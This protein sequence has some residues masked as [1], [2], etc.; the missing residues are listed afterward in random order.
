MKYLK[1]CAKITL[2]GNKLVCE[3]TS[4]KRVDY[5]YDGNGILYGLIY[6]GNK[7]FYLRDHLANILGIIDSSGNLV[8]SYDYSAYGNLKSITGSLAT[9]LGVDN[10]MRYKGYYFDEETGFYYCKSRY[11]VPEWCRWL[12]AD[13][14]SFLKPYSAT[15]NNL[16]AYCENDPINRVDY[17]GTIWTKVKDWFSNVFGLG[18]TEIERYASDPTTFGLPHIFEIKSEEV[19]V[20]TVRSFGDSSKPISLYAVL[21]TN[22]IFSSNAGILINIA[23]FSLDISFRSIDFYHTS[24]DDE[25]NTIQKGLKIENIDLHVYQSNS[26]KNGD[27]TKTTTKSIVLHGEVFLLFAVAPVAVRSM[28]SFFHALAAVGKQLLKGGI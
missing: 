8:V 21:D 3:Y 5:L 10:H 13:N 24:I 17:S 12:N 7:Y 2:K 6:N 18:Y 19:E 15:G 23:D 9:T 16:F 27:Y 20:K 25:G 28:N 22:N 14:P 26:S 11:Y 4:S 1:Q